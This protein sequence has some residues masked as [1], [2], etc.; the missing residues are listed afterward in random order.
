MH[1]GC[2]RHSMGVSVAT[3][4]SSIDTIELQKVILHSRLLDSQ[5]AYNDVVMLLCCWLSSDVVV[6]CGFSCD[7]ALSYRYVPTGVGTVRSYIVAPSAPHSQLLYSL[8]A[9]RKI[10]SS[11]S[12]AL[13]RSHFSLSAFSCNIT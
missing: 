7:A 10:A 12:R 3:K 4:R 11:N 2:T 13:G 6:A 9:R 5:S 8:E 1:F